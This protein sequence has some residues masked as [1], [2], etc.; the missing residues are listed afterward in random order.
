MGIAIAVINGGAAD[1]S[2]AIGAGNVISGGDIGI[3]VESLYDAVGSPSISI[4][5]T[6]LS[7]NGDGLV[8]ATGMT[9][10]NITIHEST[11]INNSGIGVNNL[12]T[13]MVNASG[14]W[15]GAASGPGVVGPGTGDKVSANVVYAPWCVDSACTR[16]SV[17]LGCTFGDI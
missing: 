4:T 10:D 12:G 6:S 17:V 16:L 14:N 15:W 3:D 9:A 2:V 13:G 8:V 1:P 5:G 7:S 11:I